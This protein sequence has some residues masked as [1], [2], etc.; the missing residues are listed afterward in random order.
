MKRILCVAVLLG[1]TTALHAG[2]YTWRPEEPSFK[3]SDG[4][5]LGAYT[6]ITKLDVYIHLPRAWI[7]NANAFVSFRQ[8]NGDGTSSNIFTIGKSSTNAGKMLYTV[9]NAAPFEGKDLL[10]QEGLTFDGGFV[11]R[12]SFSNA[13]DNV[14][15]GL[16]VTYD[17]EGNPILTDKWTS[18]KRFDFNGKSFDLLEQ[19][20][21]SDVYSATINIEG[22]PAP[23][24]GV[25]TLLAL[26]VA[27]LALRRKV[28]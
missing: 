25:V 28:A 16:T 1:L 9:G 8:D 2:Q 13:Q 17:F 10:T 23:E 26:G 15:H 19:T 27:G 7:Q 14:F 4:E 24:P 11:I 6:Q 3:N 21:W 18:G 12:L 20:N 5:L 22:V